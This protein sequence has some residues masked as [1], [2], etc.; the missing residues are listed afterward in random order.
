[1]SAVSNPLCRLHAL[2]GRT[3]GTCLL[4]RGL[5]PLLL[6][7]GWLWGATPVTAQDEAPPPGTEAT[8]PYRN[9]AENHAGAFHLTR[10]EGTVYATFHTDRSPVQFL[11]R[12]QPEVLFT[13]PEGFRPVLPVTW[14]VSAEPVLSDGTPHPDQPDRRVFRMQMDTAGQVRYL[15]DAGV[16]GVGYL[17]YHTMLAWPLAGTEPRLC[18]RPQYIRGSIL[19]AVKDLEE[20]T[21]H[22]SLVDWTHLARIRTLSL[23]WPVSLDT[24][25]ERQTL[26]G[27]TNLATLAVSAPDM[28][29]L[30]ELGHHPRWE[31][32]TDLL[33]HTPRLERL[34]VW[35]DDSLLVLPTGWFRY[36]PLLTHLSLGDHYDA[37][38]RVDLPDDL[39]APVPH[40][41][42]LSLG[43]MHPSERDQLL[44]Q[45]LRLTRLSLRANNLLPETLLAPVPHLTH[46]TLSSR[47]PLPETL[48]APVPHLTHLELR[49]INDPDLPADLL[50]PVPHLESL[51]L[52]S[53]SPPIWSTDPYSASAPGLVLR[54]SHVPRLTRLTVDGRTSLPDTFLEG[55]SH[56]THLT[57]IIREG[58]DLP[59]ALLAPVPRL[60]YLTV[61]SRDGLEV[62]GDW[63]APV[64]DLES[65]HLGGQYP[66]AVLAKLLTHVPRLTHLNT[67]L[68][69]SSSSPLP[70][71]F[72]PAMPRLT[73]LTLGVTDVTGTIALPEHLLAQVPAL[74]HLKLWVVGS[75]LPNGLLS[76]SILALPDGFF[77][78]APRLTALTLDVTGSLSLPT[79]LLDPVPQLTELRIDTRHTTSLPAD[80]LTQAPHL[81]TLSLDVRSLEAFPV[82]FLSHAPYLGTLSL[83]VESLEAFPAGFLSHAPRLQVF[84]LSD[85][86]YGQPPG[87]TSLPVG[88]LSH[89]PRLVELHLHVPRLRALPP[90]FLAHTPHLE[91]LELDYSR[92]ELDFSGFAN[93]L[94]LIKEVTPLTA[95]PEGFLSHTPRLRQLKLELGL[96]TAFPEDFLAHAPLL[97]HLSLDANGVSALPPDFLARHP[98]LETV[99][100]LANGV[101]DLTRG[102][103]DRSP[104][105]RS[106]LLDLQ[107]V[108]VLPEGFLTRAP[109]LHE[110]ELGVNRVA[111]LPADFLA[112]TPHLVHLDLR[113]LNLTALPADFL[114]D[115]PRL[116]TL[117]LAMPLLEPTLTPGHRLWDTLQAASL[118]V[119]VTRP[120]P[121]LF[122]PRASA[123]GSLCENMPLSDID[124]QVGD[125]LEVRERTRDDH[126]RGL[127]RVVPWRERELSVTFWND[128]CSY[129]IDA[130]F[131]EPT[132]AVC[133]ADREPDACVPVRDHYHH[134]EPFPFRG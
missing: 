70:E 75:V 28:P 109:R 12:D 91:T 33:A 61:G 74:T 134:P 51:H 82:D 112:H 81:E 106:L 87:L 94:K 17:R 130:R 111:A 127:L 18:E 79:R 38:Y 30:E 76:P 24:D 11:A 44:A 21:L 57:V 131:T 45:V 126:N 58:L 67:R 56:L 101:A 104:N 62:P 125:I 53:W 77:A 9:L 37:I 8:G 80:F 128:A 6:W 93:V 73:H 78:H 10:E 120:D 54:L 64:P 115:A 49:D 1:M 71:T 108:E 123:W 103:L 100:L 98:E 110:V 25:A 124:V 7:L 116:R 35:P 22:C 2:P 40:L 47:R 55:V 66:A 95:L 68:T 20:A 60:T 97:R 121:V 107:Q 59:D 23:S 27:L 19:A 5:L 69:M 39:L 96:V 113:A 132:L 43:D 118:R 52:E 63:L 84:R 99:R 41:E 15:D 86:E 14:E 90:G 16:D 36:I 133:A 31:L 3:V 92:Y 117:G 119:K 13:V 34:E 32:P 46:L 88:F 89:A 65:L 105:L 129:L 122:K 4:A 50:A 102:F 42:S 85:R 29:P 114:A 48:L 26:L 72:L 83:G